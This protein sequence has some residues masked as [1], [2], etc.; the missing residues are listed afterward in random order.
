MTI[1]ETPR[2]VVR[3]MTVEDAAFVLDLLNQ[4]A[5]LRFVGDKGVRTLEDAREYIRNGPLASYD[6]FGFGQYLVTRRDD[7]AP[8]GMC[9]LIKRETLDAP[10]IGF[11]FLPAYWSQGYAFESASAVLAYARGTLGLDRIVAIASPD[12]AA[13]IALLGRLGFRL[14][15]TRPLSENAAPVSLFHLPSSPLPARTS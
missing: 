2:L 13:S 4:P 5:F 8:L 7:G 10:D 6:R 15:E 11:A 1:V 9:G 12:N 14:D 3:R